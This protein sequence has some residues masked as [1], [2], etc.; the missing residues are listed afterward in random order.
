[1]KRIN[2]F[3]VLVLFAGSSLFSQEYK[4]S[5]A[6]NKIA[7]TSMLRYT[8]ITEIPEFIRFEQNHVMPETKA[9]VF[10]QSMFKTEGLALTIYDSFSDKL[11]MQHYRMRQILNDIPIEYTQYLMHLSNGNVVSMN[12]VLLSDAKISGS[13]TIS[14]EDAVSKAIDYTG[15]EE[16]IFDLEPARQIPGLADYR[17]PTAEMVYFPAG[18]SF[19]TN[20]ITPAYKI[21]VYAWKPYSRH[22]VYVDASNGKILHTE[23]R[24][25]ATDVPGT[26][27]TAY[28]GTQTITTDNTGAQ[29]RLRETGRGN[30]INTYNC[31]MTNNYNTAVDF[32]DADNYWNNVNEQLDQ[33]ATDAHF[34]TEKTYDYY[35]LIHGRNSIDNNGFQLNSYIHFNLVEQ[36][37][38]NNVNA[39]W[40]GQCMTYGD[41][42]ATRSPLTTVDICAHE[43]THGLT[44]YT[45]SLNYQD[46]SGA[47]NEAFSDIFGTTVE[48]YAVPAYADWTIG[49]DIG[50]AFRSMS[51]PKSRNLPDTYQGVNWNFS[52]SDNG[53]VHT[54]CGP[55]CYWFYLISEGGSGENDLG[56]DYSVS[57]I[58]IDAAADIAFRMLTVY[59]TNTSNYMDARFYGIQATIDFFGACSP[60]VEQVT[61]AFYAIGVGGQY[62]PEVV[63]D[64][65][66]DYNENCDAPFTVKFYNYSINGSSFIWD[67]G[68]GGSST[69]VNPQHTFTGQGEFTVSLFADGGTCGTDTETKTAY[70]VIDPDLPCFSMMPTSGNQ[71]ST[72]C[73]GTLFDSGGPANPYQDN[74]YSSFTISPAG[75]SQIM[76][77]IVQF[78]I[79]PGSGNSCD[80]DYIAFYDGAN[81]SAPLI[82]GSFYCNTTGNPGSIISSGGSI[83]IVFSSDVALA[84]QGFEIQWSCL[85]NNGSPYADFTADN[86]YS[87]NGRVQFENLSLNGAEEYLWDFGD[88]SSSTEENPLHLYNQSGVFDV[89]LTAINEYGDAVKQKNNYITVVLDNAPD[90]ENTTVCR[91][92]LFTLSAGNQTNLNWYTDQTCI[93]LVHTGNTWSHDPLQADTQY[94]LRGFNPGETLY[95]GETQSNIGGGPFGNV[96]YIHYLV[97]DAIQPFTLVSVEVNASGAGTR[98]IAL[99]DASSNNIDVKSVYCPNGISRINLGFNVP[100]GNNMQLVGLNAPNL[101]RTNEAQYLSYPYIINGIC[102]IHRSSANQNPTGYYYYFYDWEIET[103]TCESSSA[104]MLI[105]VITCSTNIDNHALQSLRIHPVP[106]RDELFISGLETGIGIPIRITDINGKTML[107]GYAVENEAI[108]VDMLPAGIYFVEIRTEGMPVYRKF[109][110][111]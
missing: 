58:G 20:E 2:L 7:G 90:I 106:T 25:H 62:V 66:S 95:V 71:I 24:L 34:A 22:W 43:I 54:N 83:T 10:L 101:F 96:S 52:S 27:V 98:Q 18:A 88:G 33:Y 31:Q 93:N 92:S 45:A 81:T 87:C 5:D 65:V 42:D 8:G 82:N 44:S 29:Y 15:A 17:Y 40:N 69:A 64:F 84:M 26:A 80:Y 49:E 57:P 35:Y 73:E 111:L 6:S 4:G 14:P 104:E 56:N 11:G 55:L 77:D 99:R 75:A 41:G 3:F 110:K 9:Q 94:W 37:Y 51:N 38:S 70:V 85:Q 60:E 30:G 102:S 13:F 68:D 105:S 89:S 97:F 46:E 79:E 91:D 47:L 28:S 108:S 67:F 100:V 16:Y 107:T 76:L 63:A 19:K 48:F 32:T 103:Q 61:R 109:I 72:H 36:G 59:L 53:G 1:M 78:D 39:F 21:D 74:T 12:G 50:Y 86:R 23:T